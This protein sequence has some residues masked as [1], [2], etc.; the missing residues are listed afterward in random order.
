MLAAFCRCRDNIIAQKSI[1]IVHEIDYGTISQIAILA[2]NETQ[3]ARSCPCLCTH[4]PLLY[5]REK[6]TELYG[7]ITC[8]FQIFNYNRLNS[9]LT[10][11]MY[12][13]I[14]IVITLQMLNLKE[15]IQPESLQYKSNE[16]R[17][18]NKKNKDHTT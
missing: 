16:Q 13:V 4:L 3:L 2:M 7:I 5:D 11:I 15:S 12:N 6:S 9:T 8:Y 1:F 10:F 14:M 18:N 17:E